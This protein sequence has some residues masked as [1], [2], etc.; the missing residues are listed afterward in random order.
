MSSF[1]HTHVKHRKGL[2]KLRTVDLAER[3]GYIKGIVK[4][5]AALHDGAA[6]GVQ[7]VPVPEDAGP[8]M[9]AGREGTHV[10][11]EALSSLVLECQGP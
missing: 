4:I 5:R 6:G 7:Q 9:A 3:H 8:H 1:F 2:A 11:G 10:A